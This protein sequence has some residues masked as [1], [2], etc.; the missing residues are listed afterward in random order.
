MEKKFRKFSNR[1][2]IISSSNELI[3]IGGIGDN[4]WL[5]NGK[6]FSRNFKQGYRVYSEYGI[7]NALTSN[8]GGI[9]GCS[10]LY[11]IYNKS[12]EN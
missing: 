10:G 4:L 2:R 11:L 5:D 6:N 1:G 12:I 9:G 8:G 3:F 7:A